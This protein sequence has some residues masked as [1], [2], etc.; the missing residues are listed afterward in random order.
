MKTFSH[1]SELLRQHTQS[2]KRYLEF[3]RV[4]TMSAGVYVLEADATDPQKPHH[5]DEMYY[6]VSGRARMQAGTEDQQVEGGSVIF[7]PAEV[8]HR[9]Y[10]ITE[11]LVV[12][13]FFAPPE[14]E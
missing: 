2:D 5:E 10:D 7:V 12:L 4:P 1:L 9:F 14:T 6:V 8:K 13:V 11:K 3:L